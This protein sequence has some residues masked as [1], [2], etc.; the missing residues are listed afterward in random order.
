MENAYTAYKKKDG[1]GALLNY[2]LAAERGY[3]VAQS[4]VAYMLDTGN[5]FFFFFPF[6]QFYKNLRIFGR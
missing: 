4:N 1:E 3:E 6:M 2:M 5:F